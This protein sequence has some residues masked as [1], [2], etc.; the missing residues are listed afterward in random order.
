MGSEYPTPRISFDD[1]NGSPEEATLVNPVIS[2]SPS[3][4]SVTLVPLLQQPIIPQT[5]L[6][7][8][9]EQQVTEVYGESPSGH[10]ACF[11]SKISWVRV[12][13]SRCCIK[14]RV[15][16]EKI[17]IDFGINVVGGQ[18]D[19]PNSRTKFNDYSSDRIGGFHS[20]SNFMDAGAGIFI[21]RCKYI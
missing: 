15:I 9:L 13:L 2:W 6:Y 18:C 17:F 4:S 19:G 7:W 3:K 12:P 16:Y 20:T 1:D 21:L 10:G 5:V 11:G 8:Q 14:E